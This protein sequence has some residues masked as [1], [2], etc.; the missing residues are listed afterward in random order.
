MKKKIFIAAIIAASCGVFLYIRA[1]NR[2]NIPVVKET[3]SVTGNWKILNITDS[4]LNKMNGRDLFEFA[5]NDSL[6][7]L[8]QFNVDSSFSVLQK[9][10][11]R[12]KGMYYTDSLLQKIFIKEDSIFDEYNIKAFTDSSFILENKKDSLNYLLVK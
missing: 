4:S 3:K 8:L 10:T 11:V 2:I 1:S 5:S 6:P 7:I 9:D 12:S